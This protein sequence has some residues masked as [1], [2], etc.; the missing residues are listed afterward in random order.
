[1]GLILYLQFL[2]C[3]KNTGNIE[4]VLEKSDPWSCSGGRIPPVP[5]GRGCP[6]EGVLPSPG[7]VGNVAMH[8]GIG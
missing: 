5:S 1:M 3:P 6:G 7:I 2:E 4:S 8:C